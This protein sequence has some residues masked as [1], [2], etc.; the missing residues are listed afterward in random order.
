A[1]DHE[2]I[3]GLYEFFLYVGIR[4]EESP[5]RPGICTV[6]DQVQRTDHNFLLY[7]ARLSKRPLIVVR[8]WQCGKMPP[9]NRICSHLNMVF[10]QGSCPVKKCRILT[11]NSISH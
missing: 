2:G 1:V 4:F 5:D 7:P 9:V 8:M 10:E 6:L 3:F 11:E